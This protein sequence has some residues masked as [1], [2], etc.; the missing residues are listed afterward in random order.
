M[1]KFTSTALGGAPVNDDDLLDIFN[2]EIWDAIQSLLSPFDADVQGVVVSGCVTTNNSGNFD[3]TA[4]IVYLNGEF[5]RVAAATNQSFTKY[6]APS[7][8][9]NDTRTYGDGTTNVTAITKGA[10]LVGSAPGSGQYLTIA[11]LTDLD[12]RRWS[13]LLVKGS[14]VPIAWTNIT[15]INSWAAASGQTPQYMVDGFGQVHFRGVLDG[16]GASSDVFAVIPTGIAHTADRDVATFRFNGSA[17][18]SK[19]FEASA[20][21]NWRSLSSSGNN[22]FFL[23]GVSYWP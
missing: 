1:K 19:G 17:F 18:E 16:T 14:R 10:G 21:G 8:A 5:M 9:V 12:D 23:D 4:G 13:T 22:Q 20:T 2:S 7:A 3:M 6:I 11:S 15:L